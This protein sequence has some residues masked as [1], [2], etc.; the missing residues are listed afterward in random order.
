MRG[1][2]LG[3]ITETWQGKAACRGPESSL[4][5]PPAWAERRDEKS[6]R[7]TRAKSIC[8]TCGVRRMCL[9]FALDIKE[10]HGIWG[11]L[12]EAERRHLLDLAGNGSN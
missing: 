7:E 2:A 6:E 1:V 4:F 5:F 12:N 8:A 9:Q 3:T 10:Q 11:G